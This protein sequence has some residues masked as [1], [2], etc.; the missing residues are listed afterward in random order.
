MK[1]FQEK[2]NVFVREGSNDS[3]IGMGFDIIN[4]LG[5]LSKEILKVTNLWKNVFSGE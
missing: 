4:E 1:D 3:P 2:V 5:E